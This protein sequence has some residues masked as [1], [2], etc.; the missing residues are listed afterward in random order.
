MT[1]NKGET[2]TVSIK[3]VIYSKYFNLGYND[4]CEQRSFNPQYDNWKYND[5]IDYERGRHY[6]AIF[7][8][9]NKFKPKI[10]KKV[11]YAAIYAASAMIDKNLLI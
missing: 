5:Q 8:N 7:G 11:N 6:A 2:V 1:H 9:S 3:T 10:G 4:H